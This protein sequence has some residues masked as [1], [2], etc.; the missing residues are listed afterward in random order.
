MPKVR[1]FSKPV[2]K[3]WCLPHSLGEEKLN[4][5]FRDIVTSFTVE[6]RLNVEGERDLVVLFP[7]DL[8]SYG[9]GTEVIIEVD[10]AAFVFFGENAS[11]AEPNQ[12]AAELAEDRRVGRFQLAT[13][14]VAALERHFPEA[15]IQCRVHSE[16]RGYDGVCTRELVPLAE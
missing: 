4:E 10:D 5:I 13:R 8:M 1:G 6:P 16:E 15:Y 11:C 2:V 3:V 9:L 14:L 12:V 7:S